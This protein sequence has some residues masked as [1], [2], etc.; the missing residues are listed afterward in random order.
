[1]PRPRFL[2]QGGT[3]HTYGGVLD[4]SMAKVR[5]RN[6]RGNETYNSEQ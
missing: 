2:V 6:T 3:A 4:A 1:M 5:A